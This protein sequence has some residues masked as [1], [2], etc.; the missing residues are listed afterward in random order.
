MFYS[1]APVK[2]LKN[3]HG[4]RLACTAV[5][6]FSWLIATNCCGLGLMARARVAVAAGGIT[7]SGGCSKCQQSPAEKQSPEK[8]GTRDCCKSVNRVQP[9]DHSGYKFAQS[10]F[11]VAQL[12]RMEVLLLATGEGNQLPTDTGPPENQSFSEKILK[13]C[14]PANAPPVN[15]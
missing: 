13:R 3:H 1:E 14:H 6:I 15:A 4:I 2:T 8:K 11:I 9:A 12:P 7:E 5:L 10:H